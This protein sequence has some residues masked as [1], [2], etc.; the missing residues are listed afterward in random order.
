M[1]VF[2]ALT[3]QPSPSAFDSQRLMRQVN[4]FR[5]RPPAGWD[6]GPLQVLVTGR[7]AY[8]S[9][10]SLSMRHDVVVTLL[11][12]VLLVGIIFF[13][14][15]QRWL[16]LIGMGFALLLSCLV[17]LAIGLLI[18]GRL[19]MATIGFSAILIGLGVDFAILI[20]GRYQQ[21]RGD[22]E[23]HRDGIATSVRKLGRAVFFGALTT[24]VGF[25]ALVLSG[26]L[27]FTQL[28]VLIAIGILFAGL[29]MC[30]ILFL[31][32]CESGKRS[33]A[34]TGFSSW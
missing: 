31:F 9:E 4:E 7:S 27:G 30:T 25:L 5:R 23:S 13:I 8:V 6:G 24:A 14:G 28:G 32:S 15:F 22:G 11:G 29:F 20:F 10:I 1:R 21:A 3:N 33:C 18:F 19:N 12:S 2:L 16:P 34:T 17:G 26:S